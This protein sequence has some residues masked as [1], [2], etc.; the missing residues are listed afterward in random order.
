MIKLSVMKKIRISLFLVCILSIFSC[1][2]ILDTTPQDFVTPTQYYKT[3]RD[4][5]SALA[6]IYDR[7]GDVR[8]YAQAMTSYLVFSDEFFMK[9]R[10]SG[11]L[12]NIIDASTLEINR[13]WES[14]YTGIERANMLL[15]NIDNAE[16]SDE[17]YNE[18]KGQA[19]FLRGYYYFML[20]DE[21]GEVPL[22]LA[23]S[24]SP[25]EPPLPGS[26]I[27]EIYEQIVKD[28]TEAEGLVKS[29]S[30]Y[31]YNTRITKTTVQGILARVYL[32]MAG[33]PLNDVAKY[34]D[35]MIYAQ[36]VIESNQHALNPDFKQIFINHSQEVFDTQE[37]LWEVEFHG[38]N[39]GEIEE[40]GMI[41]SYNGI[42]CS[43][44]DT[45]WAYDYVHATLKLYE[46]YQNGDLR[47][48]WTIAPFRF[49]TENDKLIRKP[50]TATQIYERHP[51]KWRREYEK[52]LPRTQF[53]TGTNWPLIR[54]SDVLLM[55]AE[56]D[57][58]ANGGPS[59]EAYKMLNMVRRRAYG[60]N[61]EDEDTTVDAPAGMSQYDFQLFIRDERLREFAFEGLRKHDLIRWGIYV[62]TMEDQVRK[63]QAEMPNDLKGPAVSQAQRVTSRSVVFPI[64]NSERATNPHVK[65]NEGW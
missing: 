6:G 1:N 42:S 3:E 5:E 13:H 9:G 26:P 61:L 48:D 8:M 50:W 63:Y 16:V 43:N 12:A 28:M 4:L 25:E 53:Y 19:L 20:V 29:V 49:V 57:N 41:G 52:T 60:K 46:A 65:Q 27:K 22:K 39:Q 11:I 45:G 64:P 33:S 14:I 10:T 31:G 44:I 59:D 40:G 23:S 17:K 24:K 54:Y 35:A 55:Y 30:D 21:F 2:K 38:T 18:V 37:C 36:K 34:T 56:A 58:Y 7:L 62:S 32:T 47:R 51:G 15:E